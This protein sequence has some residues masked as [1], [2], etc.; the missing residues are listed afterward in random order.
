MAGELEPM[1]AF[2]LH[3][4]D[5]YGEQRDPRDIYTAAEACAIL[6]ELDELHERAK[7]EELDWKSKEIRELYAR[8]WSQI[9]L[10]SGG[11]GDGKTLVAV[12]IASLLYMRGHQVFSNIGCRFGYVLSGA[13]L[14]GIARLPANSVV[15]LDEGH[16]LFG[17]Y[18]QMKS[19]QRTGVGGI[20]NLRKRMLSIIMPTSQEY[21][22]GIDL[23]SEVGYIF[24]PRE[25]K[26]GALTNRARAS[27]S[28]GHRSDYQ[29]LPW[30]NLRVPF[31]G[32]RPIRGKHIGE[33]YGIR[34]GGPKPRRRTWYPPA[35]DLQRAGALY[36]SYV[37]I[38][39]RFQ[40]GA[41]LSSRDIAAIDIDGGYELIGNAFHVGDDGSADAATERRRQSYDRMLEGLVAGLITEP[42]P[43]DATQITYGAAWEK[44]QP[45][46]DADRKGFNEM[47][48]EYLDGDGDTI[49]LDA[50]TRL[51]DPGSADLLTA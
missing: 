17:K 36:S 12:F 18:T 5:V 34:V 47:L 21:N 32:P 8:W 39:D 33:E 3:P 23:M 42:L 11:R 44:Y 29:S 35:Y 31:V 50:I 30:A 6:H 37:D 28:S 13:S 4:N 48:E 14:Y 25:R 41:N 49:G 9:N 46:G 1:Q 43:K 22:V 26:R 27:G 20:A 51:F 15:I 24:Y 16:T 40:S 7:T 19:S 2:R 38:P 10:L 45:H